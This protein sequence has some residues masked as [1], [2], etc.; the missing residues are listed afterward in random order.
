MT[1]RDKFLQSVERKAILL[2]HTLGP[3][4]KD[5]FGSHATCQTCGVKVNAKTGLKLS[6]LSEEMCKGKTSV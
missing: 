6:D 3:W 2:G 1:T 5:K 4:E